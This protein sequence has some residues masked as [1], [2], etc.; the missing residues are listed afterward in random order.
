M[1]EHGSLV[2]ELT[3]RR[4]SSEIPMGDREHGSFITELTERG[5][6]FRNTD[7]T[8]SFVTEVTERR[9]QFRNTADGIVRG[10]TEK[11]RESSELPMEK[12]VCYRGDRKGGSSHIPMGEHGSFVTEL[13]ERRGKLRNIDIRFV[14]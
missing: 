9:G 3:E 12:F 2:T 7:G 6:K 4:G 8:G 14:C 1:G 11:D 13:T 5:G 10:D